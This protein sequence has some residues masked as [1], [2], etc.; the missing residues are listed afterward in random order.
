MGPVTA[1][2]YLE[3]D[4]ELLSRGVSD[5]FA[6]AAGAERT[7]TA[8]RNAAKNTF[9][10]RALAAPLSGYLPPLSMSRGRRPRCWRPVRF[11]G[12][13]AGAR[14]GQPMKPIVLCNVIA[15]AGVAAIA[16][17]LA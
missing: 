2:G 5:F 4:R 9:A 16:R 11:A 13:T 12:R 3:A 6:G 14:L 8:N 7:L 10:T 15:A 1:R 17:C